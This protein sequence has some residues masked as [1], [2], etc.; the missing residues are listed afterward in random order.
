[1]KNIETIPAVGKRGEAK[2]RRREEIKK[3]KRLKDEDGKSLPTNL[4]GGSFPN[5]FIGNPENDDSNNRTEVINIKISNL[6]C[7]L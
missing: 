4:Y 1:M 3:R 2:T 5:V 7:D 6:S